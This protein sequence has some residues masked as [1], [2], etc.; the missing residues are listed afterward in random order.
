MSSSASGFPSARL[1]LFGCKVTGLWKNKLHAWGNY[2][3]RIMNFELGLRG[4]G[5]RHLSC[6]S[7]LSSALSSILP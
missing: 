7:V 6:G 2:E 1:S 5:L 4:E 3:L